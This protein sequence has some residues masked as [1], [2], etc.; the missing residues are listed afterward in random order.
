M[1]IYALLSA[2]D[3][4]HDIPETKILNLPL[5][6]ILPHIRSVVFELGLIEP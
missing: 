1:D 2:Y 3:H 5:Y 6:P 4:K